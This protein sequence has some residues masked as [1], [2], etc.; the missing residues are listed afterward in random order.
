[1]EKLMENWKKFTTQG[2]IVKEATKGDDAFAEVEAT[3]ACLLYT[4]PSPRDRG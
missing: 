1:M 4:S 2:G 3:G